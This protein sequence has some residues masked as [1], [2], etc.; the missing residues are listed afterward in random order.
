MKKQHSQDYIKSKKGYSMKEEFRDKEKPFGLTR[1]ILDRFKASVRMWKNPDDLKRPSIE[2][3]YI[4]FENGR[5]TAIESNGEIHRKGALLPFNDSALL[6]SEK[7]VFLTRDELEALAIISMGYESVAVAGSSSDSVIEALKLGKINTPIVLCS[8]M[9][10]GLEK[11]GE[12]EIEESLKQRGIPYHRLYS[13]PSDNSLFSLY[14][15]DCEKLAE[16]L[17]QENREAKESLERIRAENWQKIKGSSVASYLDTFRE[18]VR[19]GSGQGVCIPTGFPALD[20]LLD[21]GLYA[22]LYV[23]GAVS[24]LGKTSFCIQ[25]ADQI[26]KSGKPVLYFSLEMSKDE[27]ISKSISRL[28]FIDS[29]F[30]RLNVDNR[31]AKTT[32][33]ILVGSLYEGYSR[34]ELDLIE[35]CVKEYETFSQRLFIY[36]GVGEIDSAAIARILKEFVI[37]TGLCPV[38]IVDYLQIMSPKDVRLSDKQNIDQSVLD[39]KRLSRDYSIPIVGISSFNR[40]NYTNPVDYSSFKESGAIEYSSDVLLG[41]QLLGMGELPEEKG[42]RLTKARELRDKAKEEGRLGRHQDLELKILKNRNGISASLELQFYPKFNFFIATEDLRTKSD[43]KEKDKDLF[44][45]L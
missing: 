12:D 18:R 36:E 6:Q 44:S 37:A 39:L 10:D 3:L 21:G 41:L 38:V 25:L 24:S 31:E 16:I 15:E 9:R 11:R 29:R 33:G 43:K 13:C 35:R 28:T 45:I 2:V 7:V 40:E 30:K 42:A 20:T 26:A 22:G 23:I 27:I 4:P 19:N 14:R 5:Y 32:R 17:E 1:D 34:S 8:G